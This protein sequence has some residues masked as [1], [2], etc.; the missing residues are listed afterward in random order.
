MISALERRAAGAMGRDVERVM[1]DQQ[2]RIGFPRGFS[3][4]FSF[5]YTS[6][7]AVPDGHNNPSASCSTG[8]LEM[9]ARVLFSAG[10]PAVL[11]A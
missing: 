1:L 9:W 8:R 11:R 7:P 6:I 3:Q 5:S 10:N 4:G 2:V